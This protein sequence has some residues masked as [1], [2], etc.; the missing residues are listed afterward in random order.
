MKNYKLLA[1]DL[2][3]TLLDNNHRISRRNYEALKKCHEKGI[4]VILAS[5]RELKQ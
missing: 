1:I 4:Y 5:G 2:D 3:K